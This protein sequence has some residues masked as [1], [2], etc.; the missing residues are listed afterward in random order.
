MQ[1]ATHAQRNRGFTLIEI[2]AVVLIIGMLSGI[3]GFAVFQ[4]VVGD[5]LGQIVGHAQPVGFA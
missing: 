2:M 3:V 5:N 4:Q 1:S